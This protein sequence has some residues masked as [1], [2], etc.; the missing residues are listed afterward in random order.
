MVDSQRESL[1]RKYLSLGI[2]ELVA[3]AVFT[4]VTVTF[5]RPGLP[6]ADDYTAL[7]WAMTP[8]LVI[9]VQAGVYWLMAR[10]W[11]HRAPMP[12]AIAHVYRAFRIIDIALLIAGL[13]GVLAWWPENLGAALLVAGVWCFAVV[14]YV[15]YFVV[16]LAYPIGRWF[17]SVGQWRTP[18]L[19]H[20]VSMSTR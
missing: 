20:D 4:F 8:L 5:V 3:A 2:G 14:E 13:V 6:R 12:T 17:T 7:W 16:R 9:L 19:M 18:Q 15:N 10:S 11:V 1:R